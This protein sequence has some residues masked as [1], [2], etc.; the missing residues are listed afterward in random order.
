MTEQALRNTIVE[1]LLRK[2][3]TGGKKKQKTTVAGWFRSSDQGE[4]KTLL[5]EMAT[6]PTTPVE[7]YG[8][9]HRENVRLSN[10]RAAV[11]YLDRN[12]GDVPFGFDDYLDED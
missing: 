2:R 5:D 9:G 8:G 3:V 6:D 10:V 12:G 7:M 4:V 11:R 1:K